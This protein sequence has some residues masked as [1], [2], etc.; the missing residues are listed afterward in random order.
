MVEQVDQ[1]LS[2]LFRWPRIPT[3]SSPYL[4][5]IH[6]LPGCRHLL[7]REDRRIDGQNKHPVG[8]KR[9]EQVKVPEVS[10][11]H[12]F[13]GYV[14]SDRRFGTEK[15]LGAQCKQWFF[16][17]ISISLVPFFRFQA[18]RGRRAQNLS[19]FV[20]YSWVDLHDA[21]G[22]RF[23]RASEKVKLNKVTI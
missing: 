4:Y 1:A 7:P 6:H 2:G 5:G 18:Y 10:T 3:S 19:G 15:L 20:H 22:C 12:L 17:Q 14:S 13:N 21:M 8:N 11:I 9:C 23:Y 16:S